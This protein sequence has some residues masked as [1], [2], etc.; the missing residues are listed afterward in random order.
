MILFMSSISFA[1]N[2]QT[3]TEQ[4]AWQA[5]SKV[6]TLGSSDVSLG[7][8]TVLRIPST[9]AYIPKVEAAALMKTFGNT[10]GYRFY[11][12]ITSQSNDESWI[13]SIDHT[14]EGYVKDDEAAN[15]KPDELLQSIR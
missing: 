14:A 2:T 4:L 5:A 9:M 8:Q 7:D 1:Q 12:L 6:A 10:T 15:W 11:G 3:S 13:M